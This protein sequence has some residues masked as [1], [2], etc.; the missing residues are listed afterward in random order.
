MLSCEMATIVVWMAN[1]DTVDFLTVVFVGACVQYL[2]HAT[3]DGHCV[4]PRFPEP[5]PCSD[6]GDEVYQSWRVYAHPVC[7]AAP[8]FAPSNDS[9]SSRR[10]RSLAHLGVTS[11]Q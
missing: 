1:Q 10:R 9:M 5:G 6:K 8:C 7:T 2:C 11:A 3:L 4:F